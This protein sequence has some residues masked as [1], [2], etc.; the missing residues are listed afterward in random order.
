MKGRWTRLVSI[1][2]VTAMVVSQSGSMLVKADE[3]PA[4]NVSVISQEGTIEET[5][6][7]E[8]TS[9]ETATEEETSEE[10]ATEE[11][12][13]E[14]TATEEETSEEIA[15]EEETSEETATEE[16]TSEDTVTEEETTEE[17]NTDEYG[18]ALL[19]EDTSTDEV[20][21]V[22]NLRWSEDT[23]GVAIFYNPNEE[24]VSFTVHCYL[25]GE[26]I[27][28]WNTSRDGAGE[29]SLPVYYDI[30]ESGDY[31][32]IVET[33]AYGVEE[34]W[35]LSSGCISEE[36]PAFTYTRPSEQIETPK[37]IS[38]STDGVVSWN[39]VDHA[40]T[41]FSYLAYADDNYYS[42]YHE[43]GGWGSSDSFRDY[44]NELASGYD[45]YTRVRAVS[46]N[47][48]LYANSDY[49]DWVAL[50]GSATVDKTSDK[51]DEAFG[52]GVTTANAQDVAA[53]VKTAF[54][55]DTAKGE[56]QVAMQTDTETQGKIKS[57]EDAYK[58]SMGL[59]TSVNPSDDIGIDPSSVSL[60]GAALNATESGSV[61]FNM[62]KPDEETQKDLITNSRFT[63]AIVLDLELEGAG[64]TAGESLAIPVTVTMA[65]PEGIDINKLTILHY[66]ADGT[67]ENLSVR[68]NAD[69]TISFTVTHFSN[70]VF[71][72]KQQE[73]VSTSN[74]SSNTY[75]SSDDGSS[76]TVY[77]PSWKPTTPDEIKRY[78]FFGKEKVNFVAD[79]N[80]AYPVTI[81]NAMQG[82]LCFDVFE[83]VLGDYS[84]GRTYNIYPAKKTVYKMDSAAKITLSIP[85][86]LQADNRDYKM[87]CVS[88]DGQPIVLDDL[89]LNPDTITFETDSYY[90]FALV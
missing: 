41:Y 2:G 63:K 47:I 54:A 33:F 52:D 62:S 32:F 68:K 51:L 30:H 42:G 11:E 7:E 50:D 35:D 83:A 73:S 44:S 60:L 24:N 69:G 88:K 36:S 45:Y 67:Y 61:T 55:D 28:G 34:D 1:L 81:V 57:L 43:I 48:N 25:D 4:D 77:V 23:P 29:V 74:G 56:L 22:T 17:E 26:S 84:I 15:T 53:A 80:N 65:A 27:P 19:A 76:S 13:S 37:N 70:F 40:V 85:K 59:E 20:Q 78:S 18:I 49:S 71:G 10:T 12:T 46:E 79:V 31:T 86:A 66:N 16:E 21:P 39:K 89:D 8:G 3:L 64:I 14:E 6:T 82:K 75:A 72:E 58:E 38:W 5:A 87:I 90:A 9:E